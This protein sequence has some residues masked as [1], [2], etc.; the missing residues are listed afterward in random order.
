MRDYEFKRSESLCSELT[1]NNKKWAWFSIYKL[2]ESS[3]RL[4]FFEKLTISLSK[5]ILKY[6]HILTI[7]DFNIEMKSKSLGC[8]KL[9]E[10]YDLFNFTNLIKSE[11]CFIK[12]QKFLINLFLT[13]AFSKNTY[14]WDRFKRLS[15][16]NNNLLQD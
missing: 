9:D 8:D 3:N 2:L 4:M 16:T 5:A 12:N 14:K 13:F 7:D 6:E 15:Q 1:F 11:T 10:F